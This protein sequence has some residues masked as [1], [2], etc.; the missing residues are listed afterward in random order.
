MAEDVLEKDPAHEQE[1]SEEQEQDEFL[2]GE[3]CPVDAVREEDQ[4]DLSEEDESGFTEEEKE[5]ILSDLA[6]KACQRDLTSYRLEIRDCW[7]ARY[8]WRGNQYLL[9]GKNGAWVLPQMILVGGQSYD[10]HN[11]E[12]NIYL[13][14]GD[15]IIAALTAGTPSVRFEPDDPTNPA[16][17]QAADSSDGARRLIERANNMIVVQEDIARFLW[18]D[19]RCCIYTHYVLDAQRFGYQQEE[20]D[21]DELEYLPE[22]GEKAGEKEIQIDRGEPRGQEVIEAFG[23]METKIAIQSNDIEGTDYL[24][25]S[26]EFDITRLKTKYPKKAKQLKPFQTPTANMEYARL[27]RT[28]IMTGMRPSNMT[29]DAMTYNGTEQLSWFRPAFYR[30]IEDEDKRNWLYDTFPTGCMVAMV[31]KTVCEARRESIDDHWT[32]MHSRPGDGAHRPALGQPIIPLQEKLNDCMDYI[33]DAFMHLIPIK[34]VDSEAVDTEALQEIQIKPGLYMKMKRKPDKALA[35][36]IFVEPQIQLAEGLLMYVQNL[37]GEFA[38]FLCGAFPALFGGNTGTNDTASGIA[39]QR[40][41]ALGR[42]GLTWRSIKA[43]YARIIRQAVAAA[44]K[45]RNSPMSGKLKGA[46]GKEETLNI[47]PEDLKGNIRCYPDTD[48]NF[49]E[50]WVAQRAVWQA[51]MAA[52]ATNPILQAI[53]SVPRNLV[54][55]K[56]KIGLPEVVVPAAAAGSKQAAEIMILMEGEPIENPKLDQAKEALQAN[57]PPPEGMPPEQATLMQQQITQALAAIPPLISTVPVDEKLDDHLNEMAEIKTWASQPEGIKARVEKPKSFANVSLHF[58]EH[59]RA[60]AAQL[61]KQQQQNQPPAKPISE[62]LSLAFKDLP[63]E[64]QVQAAKK[65]GI[66]LDPAKLVARAKLDD[67]L[68]V[69]KVHKPAAMPIPKAPP[70]GAPPQGAPPAAAPAQ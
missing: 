32:L 51:L 37:F 56:D 53:L 10:D 9:P 22:K 27:A 14:F 8:F 28:S 36:N 61:A 42:I 67:Q 18:T 45:F 46:G 59:E 50:S 11:Q 30:E 7:K 20:N 26:G 17:V 39:S 40:D 69:D 15:T 47:D 13:A 6:N 2:P 21:E 44:A 41:Q 34:W 60:L 23:A 35:E 68:E 25:K 55:A 64:G 57:G 16:D 65:F 19:A 4:V 49:P 63:P 58:D 43:G 12:T 54:T 52:A 48:E 33:H 38:Q 31:G 66:N 29:Q 5:G 62:G 24:I 3:L 70:E 1:E